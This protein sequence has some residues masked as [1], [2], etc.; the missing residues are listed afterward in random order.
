[1]TAHRGEYEEAESLA[2]EAVAFGE[3][4]DMLWPRGLALDL[5][6][7]LKAAGSREEAAGEVERALALFEEK[8]DLAM[9]DQSRA[10]LEQLL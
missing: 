4:T 1:V 6:E 3:S 7:V 10:R 9:V 8:G 5:A 2:R